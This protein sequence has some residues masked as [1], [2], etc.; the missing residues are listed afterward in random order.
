MLVPSRSRKSFVI[1]RLLEES[2]EQSEQL[3]LTKVAGLTGLPR[4]EFKDKQVESMLESET[5][6]LFHLKKKILELNDLES[7]SSPHR[8][9]G[10]E[11]MS[12]SF[13]ESSSTKPTKRSSAPLEVLQNEPSWNPRSN[14]SAS[15][16]SFDSETDDLS[17]NARFAA[18]KSKIELDES[19]KSRS[20]SSNSSPKD[21]WMISGDTSKVCSLSTRVNGETKQIAFVSRNQILVNPLVY[22]SK[23]LLEDSEEDQ[24]RFEPTTI[25]RI[26]L[27]TPAPSL[28]GKASR[29]LTL[30]IAN[31]TNEFLFTLRNDTPCY[32]IRPKK[33]PHALDSQVQISFD[34]S[35]PTRFTFRTGQGNY[36]AFIHLRAENFQQKVVLEKGSTFFVDENHGF[37]FSRFV[38]GGDFASRICTLRTKGVRFFCSNLDRSKVA[39]IERKTNLSISEFHKQK[40]GLSKAPFFVL[41]RVEFDRRLRAR[42][43]LETIVVFEWKETSSLFHPPTNRVLLNQASL[44]SGEIESSYDH[45]SLQLPLEVSVSIEDNFYLSFGNAPSSVSSPQD[46]GHQIVSSDSPKDAK[47]LGLWRQLASFDKFSGTALP[48]KEVSLPLGSTLMLEGGVV[49]L[50]AVEALRV[51]R[52]R[53]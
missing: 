43:V 18:S 24:L 7:R 37:S 23:I 48:G 4:Y 5:E 11:R 13:G 44:F 19:L 50:A 12:K 52:L 2:S 21:R 16:R 41:E 38:A 14:S 47:S 6:R 28:R 33:V 8:V 39:E 53:R 17:S 31:D 36:G 34:E 51:A 9:S 46:P 20:Q 42:R 40:F 30:A 27:S 35:S 10:L 32:E 29:H 1:C 25:S 49:E 45:T 22:G 26:D 15:N 3:F